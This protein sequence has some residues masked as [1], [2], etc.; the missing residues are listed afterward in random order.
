MNFKIKMLR[1]LVIVLVIY[2]LFGIYLF[3]NQKSMIYFPDKQD[4]ESCSGFSDYQKINHSRTRFYFKEGSNEKVIIY[5]HGNA[6]SACDR[7]Y[8]RSTFEKSDASLIFVEYAGYSNDEV[9]PSKNLILKDVENIRDYIREKSFNNIIIYGQSVGSGAASYH[10]SLGN[11]DTLI[12]ATPFSKLSDVAQAAYKIYP[13]K[14]LLKEEYDNTKWLQN[15]QGRM[16]ILHGDSD[17]IIPSKLS[18]KLFESVPSQ[19]KE[20]FSVRGYG[21]NDIWDSEIFKNKIIDFI[22]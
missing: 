3:L 4:F 22:K 10:A 13:A 9:K 7:S 5:Y 12:L 18:K 11:V 17:R 19:N 8:F 1:I 16:L 20:Y 2:V 14:L 15:Y 21:H 6:G